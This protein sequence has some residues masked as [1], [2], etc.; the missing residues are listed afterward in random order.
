[1]ANSSAEA[2]P[3][4]RDSRSRRGYVRSP[5]DHPSAAS[6]PVTTQRGRGTAGGSRPSTSSFLA[7]RSDQKA[8]MVQRGEQRGAGDCQN[9]EDADILGREA[10][11]GLGGGRG[12]QTG[13]RN[14][15]V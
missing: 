15:R 7:L 5:G 2:G 4:L 6:T 14:S 9:I 11:R 1:M 13:P 8:T 10:G 12:L 3:I